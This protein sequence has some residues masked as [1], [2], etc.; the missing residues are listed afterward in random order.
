VPQGH[1]N[2][3]WCP[4]QGE[5]R[6]KGAATIATDSGGFRPENHSWRTL[7]TKDR[8]LHPLQPRHLLPEEVRHSPRHQRAPVD[9]TPPPEQ[10]R[11]SITA[12]EKR[13]TTQLK[14]LLPAHKT[15]PSPPVSI[16]KTQIRQAQGSPT[17]AAGATTSV[18]A[19]GGHHPAPSHVNRHRRQHADHRCHQ[20]TAPAMAAAP[21][22]HAGRCPPPPTGARP[23][24]ATSRS[25]RDGAGSGG[26]SLYRHL[27]R[28]RGKAPAPAPSSTLELLR[29][30][31]TRA[32]VL[33]PSSPGPPLHSLG[34]SP[35]TQDP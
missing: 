16:R 18:G 2:P 7:S 33:P 22:R 24:R 5:R 13:R 20:S 19:A 17:A 23:R 15:P 27:G 29:P 28:Q 9:P 3:Q 21:N 8:G 11:T 34:I 25:G 35:P 6:P 30:P 31:A 10:C 4:R 12:E 32:T 1:G 26:P 14:T